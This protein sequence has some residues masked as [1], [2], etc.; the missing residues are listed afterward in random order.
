MTA[1]ESHAGFGDDLLAE[2]VAEHSQPLPPEAT[3]NI[4]ELTPEE[5]AA[6]GIASLPESL[7]EAIDVME[8]SELVAEA[9]GEHVFE[10]FVRTKRAEW[11]DYRAQ[12]TPFELTRYL[13]TL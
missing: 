1:R 10:H 13:G 3:N 11:D 7:G 8:R 2:L 5:R 9:L 4:F 12:V 6:E